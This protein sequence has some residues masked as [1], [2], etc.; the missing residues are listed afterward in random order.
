MSNSALSMI[1]TS[2]IGRSIQGTDLIKQM[3]F[4]VTFSTVIWQVAFAGV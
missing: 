2:I 3:S 1:L 4:E